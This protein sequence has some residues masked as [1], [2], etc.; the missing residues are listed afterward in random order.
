MNRST[1]RI[2][3][4]VAVASSVVAIVGATVVAPS[5]SADSAPRD[6]RSKVFERY[7]SLADYAESDG[8]TPRAWMPKTGISKKGWS[9]AIEDE[10]VRIDSQGRALYIDPLHVE[11]APDVARPESATPAADVPLTNAFLLNSLPGSNRTIYLDF[12]GHSLVG[13]YWQDGGTFANASINYTNAQMQ[14]PAYDVDGN[15]ATFSDLE[16]RNIIDAWSA[17]AEDYAPFNVNVTTADP[18]DAA[19]LRSNEFDTIYGMR[20]LITNNTNAIAAECRCGGV[21]YV[22]VFGDVGYYNNTYMGPSLNFAQNWFSGKTISDVVSHEVGHNVGLSHDG[23]MLDEITTEGYYVG[24]DGWAPIMGVGYYEPLVQ[25]ST[26]TYSTEEGKAANNPEDDYVVAVSNGLPLRTDDHGDT[27]ETASVLGNGTNKSGVISTRADVDY[28]S[29]IAR[30]T[31]HVVS[32]TSPSLSSNLD[33]Q[34]EL[35]DS[36]GTLLSTTNPDLFRVGVNSATGLDAV[37]TA[38]T[39]PGET[40]FIALD[41][42]G[43]G[44]GT[45]TGYSDYGSL[46]EYRINVSGLKA[47]DPAGSVT[48]SGT[49]KVAKTLSARPSG[50]MKR[51]SSHYQWLR[52]GFSIPNATSSK[53]KLTVTDVGRV[54]SMRL[55]VTKPGYPSITVTSNPTVAV[56]NSRPAR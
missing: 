1:F 15:T 7:Q 53:Y 9:A 5:S 12:T 36:S 49:A 28:F 46:G 47:I 33:V 6:S 54:I 29:F 48:I 32:V 20:A 34:A 45:T 38:T 37:F 27:Q 42:A 10:S 21:A 14:M 19:L 56:A 4:F 35:F 40:Y 22:G 23:L 8:R 13:T 50:W 55:T 39:T 43:Y 30:A 51:V 26:G 44:P 52:N 11:H 3:R 17:I 41:G 25:L 24:R 2:L 16:R 18:G 31:S